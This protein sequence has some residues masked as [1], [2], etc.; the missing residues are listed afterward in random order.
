MVLSCK[1]AANFEKKVLQYSH[2][3]DSV[4]YLKLLKILGIL[5][6]AIIFNGF[7]TFLVKFVDWNV[8]LSQQSFCMKIIKFAKLFIYGGNFEP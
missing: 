3:G 4:Q 1:F 2:C 6:F 8:Y 5:W 7:S